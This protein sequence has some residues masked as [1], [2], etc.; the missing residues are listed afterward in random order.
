MELKKTTTLAYLVFKAM[1]NQH[2]DNTQ[3]LDKILAFEEADT[4]ARMF[5]TL[6]AEYDRDD[7]LAPSLNAYYATHDKLGQSTMA[8]ATIPFRHGDE[9]LRFIFSVVENDVSEE[10]QRVRIVEIALITATPVDMDKMVLFRIKRRDTN[11]RRFGNLELFVEDCLSDQSLRDNVSIA[12]SHLKRRELVDMETRNFV[13]V[14]RA[15]LHT[16]ENHD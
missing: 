13:D 5:E 12:L 7:I 15:A 11:G 16:T 10:L 3:E 14:L 2:I 9:E 8:T 6:P 4:K 1:N